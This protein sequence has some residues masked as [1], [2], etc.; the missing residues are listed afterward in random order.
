MIQLYLS[1]SLIIGFI[2]IADAV[3]LYKNK[4]VF[5]KNKLLTLTTNIEFIW[6]IVTII[7]LFKLDFSQWLILVPSL[8]IIH[9]II[10]WIYGFYLT[11]KSPEILEGKAPIITPM[12]YVYFCLSY[13][14]IFTVI[15]MVALIV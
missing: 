13:S 7:A 3:L 4:G 12:W 10:G 14:I 1:S 11:S 15:C 9:N 2:I 5:G 6:A 8:Y